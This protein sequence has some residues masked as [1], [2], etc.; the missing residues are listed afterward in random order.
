MTMNKKFALAGLLATLVNLLLNA[1][2]YFVV[3]KDFYQA[4]PAVSKE[5][6]QQ[7]ARQPDQLIGWALAVSAVTMGLLITTVMRWSGARSFSSGLRDGLVLAVLF[8]SS[9]NFGLYASSN[10]FSQASALVDLACS[11]TAMA[12][13]AALAAWVLG[14]GNS[15]S[16]RP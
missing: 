13:S 4:H 2:A 16:V 7:L 1:G 3:L 12:L 6:Q 14:T 8:W 15:P 10:H 11:V 5:F 9:I